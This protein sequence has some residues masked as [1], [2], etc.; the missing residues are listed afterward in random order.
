MLA[1][2]LEERGDLQEAEAL[3]RTASS[4]GHLPATSNLALLLEERGDLQQAEA[5]YR[6]A[7]SQGHLPATSNLALLLEKLVARHPQAVRAGGDLQEAEAL[8]RTASSQGHLEA[9][10]NLAVL[11]EKRGDLQ[12]A[13]ALCRTASMSTEPYVASQHACSTPCNS[14]LAQFALGEAA[15]KSGDGVQV[16]GLTSV[17]AVALNGHCATVLPCEGPARRV[18]GDRVPVE[19]DGGGQRLVGPENSRPWS[20]VEELGDVTA[21]AT[22][23]A[24]RTAATSSLADGSSIMTVDLAFAFGCEG[25]LEADPATQ[26]AILE[27]ITGFAP[28]ELRAGSSSSSLAVN[29][30]VSDALLRSRPEEELG[31]CVGKVVLL[32]FNRCIQSFQRALL[33]R[34][35]LEPVRKALNQRGFAV[36]LPSKAKAF[37]HPEN[38]EAVLEAIARDKFVLYADHVLVEPELENVVKEVLKGIA[39]PKAGT[40]ALI[41]LSG[42]CS[43]AQEHQPTAGTAGASSSS[44][45]PLTTE[46]TFIH[47]KVPSSLISPSELDARSFKTA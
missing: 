22:G 13:E 45:L 42:A 46:R 38:Y 19:I 23:S 18:S 41:E 47:F 20:D 29:S 16:H 39:Q 34:P 33:Q 5:L 4:Q 44:N 37:V 40:R 2:L 27:S 26:S 32:K 9:T 11:L 30:M 25:E 12:E 31:T 6:T 43:G 3:Y 7:S 17:G 21:Q 36:V 1:S 15:F 10:F 8:Y 35:E 24:S 28:E 14:K